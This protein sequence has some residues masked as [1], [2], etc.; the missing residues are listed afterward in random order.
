MSPLSLIEISS[1]RARAHLLAG[2]EPPHAS[3]TGA[4]RSRDETGAVAEGHDNKFALTGAIFAGIL[5]SFGALAV[6]H[7]MFE[8]SG[9]AHEMH[10]PH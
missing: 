3:G 7:S 1:I 10:N 8:G 6:T 2:D 9:T 4:L 5:M